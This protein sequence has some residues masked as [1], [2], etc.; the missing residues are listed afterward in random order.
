MSRE[1]ENIHRKL[2][3]MLWGGN[4]AFLSAPRIFSCLDRSRSYIGGGYP[5][6]LETILKIF[7]E[8][9]MKIVLVRSPSFLA[10]LLRKFFGI[11]KK[12]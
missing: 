2:R 9:L 8:A 7:W 6:A 12:K 1:I 3:Y 11:S 10:P 4:L 5:F